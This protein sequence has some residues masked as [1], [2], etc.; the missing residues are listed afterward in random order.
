VAKLH[1]E[2]VALAFACNFNRVATLQHGDG[3]DQTKYAVPSN[4]SLGWPFHHLSH[5]V[6]SD[7]TSGNNP[8]AEQAHAEIDVLRMH[9]LLYGLDQ[10]KARGLFDKSFIMWTN[11]IAD[12]PSHSFRNVPTIIAGDAGGYLKQGAFVDAGNSTNNKL[13]NTLINAAVRDKM[14]WTE[15]LGQGSGSGGLE[16]IVT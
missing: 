11:Q 16:A 13:L 6:Q 9:T 2:L 4:A 10:F 8:T 1:F 5:R 14:A 7:S 3:T 15:N 12:G